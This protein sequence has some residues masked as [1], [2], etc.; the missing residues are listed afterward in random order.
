[1]GEVG[2]NSLG[3]GWI[4]LVFQSEIFNRLHYNRG[5]L[6]D[7]GLQ[8]VRQEMVGDVQIDGT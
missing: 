3:H 8:H 2:G 7:V 4:A 5:Y 1:M 6:G